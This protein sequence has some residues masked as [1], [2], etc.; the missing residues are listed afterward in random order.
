MSQQQTKLSDKDFRLLKRE[1]MAVLGESGPLHPQFGNDVLDF[2][3]FHV[4]DLNDTYLKSGISED[5]NN[6]DD[7]IQLKP[8]NDLRKV[9]F[10]RGDYKVKYFFYRRVAGAD[11][12]VLTKTVGDESGKIHSGNPHLTGEAMGEFYVDEDGKVFQGEKPPVNGQPSELDIK[13]YKFFIDEVSADRKEVRL[14][15][16]MINLDKYRDEFSSLS[17]EFGSYTSVKGISFALV[18]GGLQGMGKFSGINSTGFQIDNKANGDPG[19]KQKYLDGTLEVTNAFT[20]GYTE[21][22]NTNEND[23]WSLEDPIPE[24]DLR[25][26]VIGPPEWTEWLGTNVIYSVSNKIGSARAPQDAVPNIYDPEDY[27]NLFGDLLA[28]WNGM[29][30]NDTTNATGWWATTH[31]VTD[32][33]SFG[34]K[35]WNENG[36]NESGR[37]KRLYSH[38][39]GVKY[40]WD[41]GCGHTEITDIPVATHTYDVSPSEIKNFIPS[42]TIMTPNFTYTPDTLLDRQDRT[43]NKVTVGTI[44]IPEVPPEVLSDPILP[45]GSSAMDGKI[46]YWDGDDNPQGTPQK[47]PNQAVTTNTRFYVQ[48]GHRRWITSGYNLGLL[49]ELKGLSGSLDVSL[50]TNLMNTLPIGPQIGGTQL[51]G[52]STGLDELITDGYSLGSIPYGDDTTDD[53]TDETSDDPTDDTGNNITVTL[54][55]SPMDMQQSLAASKVRYSQPQGNSTSFV[56]TVDAVSVEQQFAPNTMVTVRGEPTAGV[57]EWN[58]WYPSAEFVLS[59]RITNNNTHNFLASDSITLYAK[60]DSGQ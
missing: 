29:S 55:N 2:V 27:V 51:T 9:G 30:N 53:T 4:Y 60:V 28:A 13:E 5:F 44:P 54:V 59:E 11:E 19:F 39:N 43:L 37:R 8:G 16:Q 47:S 7:T 58:G 18:G 32:K 46:I 45:A 12:V 34:Q 1:E 33:A 6:T 14:A 35:H 48:S 17:D 38:R 15:P 41:F 56:P 52:A 20:V 25:V 49:R 3:K 21:H 22:T 10:T 50:Y 40:Y 36:K 24:A 42:V 31:G 23:D 26:Y 57:N